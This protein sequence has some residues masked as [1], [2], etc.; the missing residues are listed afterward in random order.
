MGGLLLLAAIVVFVIWINIKDSRFRAQMTPAEREA[1]D[2]ETARE[3]Q[4]W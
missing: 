2:I 4:I 3:A 1:E